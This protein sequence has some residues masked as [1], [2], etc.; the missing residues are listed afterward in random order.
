[1]QLCE[2]PSSINTINDVRFDVE[3]M[4]SGQKD[5]I[6]LVV[7]G[8]HTVDEDIKNVEIILNGHW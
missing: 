5:K 1:M 3:L 8:M 7:M 2:R 6:S 4:D